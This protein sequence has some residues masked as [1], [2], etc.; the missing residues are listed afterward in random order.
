[1]SR[2]IQEGGRRCLPKTEINMAKQPKHDVAID[3]IKA[4]EDRRYRARKLVSSKPLILLKV[5][6]QTVPVVA[7]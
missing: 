7:H 6:F 1:M 2:R 4:L 5:G 3:E